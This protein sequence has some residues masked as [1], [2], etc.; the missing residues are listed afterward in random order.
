MIIVVIRVVL[1]IAVKCREKVNA[2]LLY[3]SIQFSTLLKIA[4]VQRLYLYSVILAR[5]KRILMLQSGP[6]RTTPPISSFTYETF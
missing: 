3:I 6:R 5:I 2:A 1:I 4:R